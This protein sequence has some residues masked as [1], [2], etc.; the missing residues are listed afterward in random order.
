MN[1]RPNQLPGSG[2]ES[3]KLLDPMR[4][5]NFQSS[6]QRHGVNYVAFECSECTITSS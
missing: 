4:R 3:A 1:H 6:T 5:R 2:D